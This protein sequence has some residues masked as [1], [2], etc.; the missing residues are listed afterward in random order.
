MEEQ[1]GNFANPRDLVRDAILRYLYSVHQKARGPKKTGVTFREL[2]KALKEHGYKQQEVVSNLDYL[3]QKGWIREVVES[4]RFT[5]PR[6]TVRESERRSYK[7]SDTG[8]DRLEAASTFQRKDVSSHVNITNIN[9]V[10][11]V[12]DGN[13]VNTAFVDAARVLN[14]IRYTVLSTDKLSDD[15]KLSIASD[16]ES[17]QSQLQKP[18]PNRS[19][20]KTLWSGVEKV[21]TAAGFAELAARAASLIRPLL[22]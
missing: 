12:G 11:V 22:S 6:G 20:I 14:E 13:V 10:T 21:V 8:V 3:I 9:G 2:T 18:T 1:W 17:L 4:R 16:V 7:V 15:E 19:V 5:T